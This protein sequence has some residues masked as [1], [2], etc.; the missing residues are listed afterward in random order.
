MFMS[1]DQHFISSM[2]SDIFKFDPNFLENEEK[3]RQI[4]AEIL[5]EDEDEESGSEESED[6]DEDEDEGKAIVEYHICH[7]LTALSQLS[8]RRPVLRTVQKPI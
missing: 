3:Y 8:R 6:E 1:G 7:I 5:G 2:P 4:K